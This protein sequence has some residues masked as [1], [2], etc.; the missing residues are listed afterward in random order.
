MLQTNQGGNRELVVGRRIIARTLWT[1]RKF[2]HQRDFLSASA[3]LR[4]MRY[5]L[6]KYNILTWDFWEEYLEESRGCYLLGMQYLRYSGLNQL[7]DDVFNT[8][9]AIG[10]NQ[11]HFMGYEMLDDGETYQVEE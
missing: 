1:A 6:G 11:P 7:P 5:I 4:G 2:V 10:W 9:E 8:L 3:A